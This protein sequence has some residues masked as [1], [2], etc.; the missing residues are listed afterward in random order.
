MSF[1]LACIEHRGMGI[2]EPELRQNSAPG[3]RTGR[4]WSDLGSCCTQLQAFQIF[5]VDQ[6]PQGM[7]PFT[8]RTGFSFFIYIKSKRI[9][10]QIG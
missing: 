5:I 10:L 6:N 1:L 4:G 3:F 2:I 9:K 7:V 8:P